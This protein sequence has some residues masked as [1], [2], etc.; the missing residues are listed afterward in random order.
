M[1]NQCVFFFFFP[2]PNR[3]QC[4]LLVPHEYVKLHIN[5]IKKQYEWSPNLKM[6][7]QKCS[8]N[9]IQTKSNQAK[10][11]H[12]ITQANLSFQ[13]WTYPLFISLSSTTLRSTDCP[14]SVSF[15]TVAL[16]RSLRKP[17]VA[18][19]ST[20]SS[21]GTLFALPT[22]ADSLSTLDAI[23]IAW[24]NILAVG[25]WEKLLPP[26][27]SEGDVEDRKSFIFVPLEPKGDSP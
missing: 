12:T 11:E 9:F 20:T 6:L 16:T 27:G 3:I 23:G 2:S 18:T 21:T 26:L 1:H 7:I 8:S 10:R 19:L 24:G 15:L 25:N 5:P 22:E 4:D 17:I 14:F 13:G